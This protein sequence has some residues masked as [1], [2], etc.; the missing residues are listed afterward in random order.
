MAQDDNGNV[1]IHKGLEECGVEK[2]IIRGIK[3]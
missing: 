3:S 1:N 2:G